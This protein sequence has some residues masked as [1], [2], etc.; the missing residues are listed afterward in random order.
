VVSRKWMFHEDDPTTR[1]R[2]VLNDSIVHYTASPISDSLE[3]TLI[4]ANGY[5]CHDTACNIYPIYRGDIWVP[6]AFTPGRRSAGQNS[7]FKVKYNNILEYEINIYTREGLLVFHS[8]DPDI[9]WN[10]TYNYKDCKSGSY[11]YVVRYATKKHPKLVLEQKG[12]V[13]LIR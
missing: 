1:D 2:Q 3:V 7:L 6:N 8:T 4:V 12:M 13:L 11:V 9:S 5:G 10:G